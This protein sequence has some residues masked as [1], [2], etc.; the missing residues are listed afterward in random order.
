MKIKMNTTSSTPDVTLNFVKNQIRDV[1]VEEAR[2]WHNLG[3]CTLLEPYPGE[4]EKAVITA[5]EKSVIKP[6]ETA[7]VAVAP[8]PVKAP[9]APPAVPAGKSQSVASA[10]AATWGT[11]ETK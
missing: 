1:T 10:K 4:A 6:P 9:V 7:K 11:P 2:Y 8:E 3:V 5:P